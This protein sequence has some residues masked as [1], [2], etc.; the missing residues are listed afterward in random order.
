MS[1][2]WDV[3]SRLVPAV[4]PLV[5]GTIGYVFGRKSKQDRVINELTIIEKLEGYRACHSVPNVDS[6]I[7]D[8][9][10]RLERSLKSVR[11]TPTSEKRSKIFLIGSAAFVSG[12]CIFLALPPSEEKPD[13]P[14]K[15]W[16][17]TSIGLT[18]VSTG[19]FCWLGGWQIWDALKALWAWF[20]DRRRSK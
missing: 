3:V 12:V 20:R 19:I 7:K 9:R 10:E 15:I 11:K 8:S 1:G 6:D 14:Y 2:A 16:A 4:L 18:V 13:G 17:W 5:A